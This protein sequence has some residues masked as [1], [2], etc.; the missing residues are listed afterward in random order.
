MASTPSRWHPMLSRNLLRNSICTAVLLVMALFVLYPLALLIYGSFLV[1]FASS[2]IATKYIFL[3]P[4]FRNFAGS[5]EEASTM[6]GSSPFGTIRRIVMPI[7][8]PAILITMAISLTH[9]LESFEIEL[10]LGPPTN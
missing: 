1:N 8:M 2:S 9:S 6:A 4:A 3:A 7:L 5:L 10:V